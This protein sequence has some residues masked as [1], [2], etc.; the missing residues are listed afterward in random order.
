MAVVKK[1]RLFFSG[2]NRM[3]Y[4]LGKKSK[5]RATMAEKLMD[6]KGLKFGIILIITVPDAQRE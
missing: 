5:T 3:I 4:S 2:L 1:L 6:N